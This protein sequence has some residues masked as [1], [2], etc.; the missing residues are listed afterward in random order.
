VAYWIKP[1]LFIAFNANYL[2]A[3]LTLPEGKWQLVVDTKDDWIFHENGGIPIERCELI[4]YSAI[5]MKNRE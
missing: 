1:S 3:T 4:P 2:P 5:V